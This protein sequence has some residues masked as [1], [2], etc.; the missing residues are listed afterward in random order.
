MTVPLVY[1]DYRYSA[2]ARQR[3][4]LCLTKIEE[5][6]CLQTDQQRATLHSQ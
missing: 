6:Y 4:I 5:L 2:T 3:R 1:L